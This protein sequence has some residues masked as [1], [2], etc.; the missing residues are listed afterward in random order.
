MLKSF[1]VGLVIVLYNLLLITVVKPHV[2][3]GY[4]TI[5][6][7]KFLFIRQMEICIHSSQILIMCKIT[8]K[9]IVYVD[10]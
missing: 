8:R 5:M 1:L 4:V 3:L 7:E 6:K 2:G 9:E 10:L